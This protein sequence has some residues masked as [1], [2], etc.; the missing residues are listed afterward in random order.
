MSKAEDS[1]APK[2]NKQKVKKCGIASDKAGVDSEFNKIEISTLQARLLTLETEN[3]DLKFRVDILTSRNKVLEDDRK[4]SI[5]EKYFGTKSDKHPQA[6]S[7]NCIHH[8]N[9]CCSGHEDNTNTV[10]NSNSIDK[11]VCDVTDLKVLV[12]RINDFI[13]NTNSINTEPAFVPDVL[14]SPCQSPSLSQ[15]NS[16]G[17]TALETSVISIDDPSINLNNLN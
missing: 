9:H 4:N 8:S 3:N 13:S 2:K 5:H 14:A 6:T 16:Q 7:T 10:S 12:K 1:Q 11:I 15:L 17:E